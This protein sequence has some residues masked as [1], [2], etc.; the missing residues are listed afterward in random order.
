MLV[1]LALLVAITAWLTL[2]LWAEGA[3]Y[4]LA[5]AACEDNVDLHDRANQIVEEAVA[6]DQDN[7]STAKSAV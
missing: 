5:R 4:R 3:T 2:R 6:A 7:R 1:F